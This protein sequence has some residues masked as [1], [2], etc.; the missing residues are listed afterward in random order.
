[1]GRLLNMSRY[2]LKA[3]TD[4]QQVEV[5]DSANVKDINKTGLI[6][7]TYGRKF[8]LQ[9]VDGTMKTYDADQLTFITSPTLVD[10]VAVPV[11]AMDYI[12]NGGLDTITDQERELADKFLEDIEHIDPPSQDPYVD[13]IPFWGLMQN[14][15]DCPVVFKAK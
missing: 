8:H 12:F 1:M 9:F 3:N 6:V 4:W 14:F 15:Y 5:G 13:R 2:T 7:H 10:Q 11:W